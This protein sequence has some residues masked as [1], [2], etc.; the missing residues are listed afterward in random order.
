MRS[1]HVEREYYE[2]VS[3]S[4]F[5]HKGG[6]EKE[7][8]MSVTPRISF[9]FFPPKTPVGEERLWQAIRELERSLARKDRI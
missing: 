2:F 1:A 3:E 8:I 6:I 7:T 9:E 4:G 5:L